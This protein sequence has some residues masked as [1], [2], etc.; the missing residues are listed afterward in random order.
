MCVC[1]GMLPAQ[2]RNAVGVAILYDE[3]TQ[4]IFTNI[5]PILGTKTTSF[6]YM[7]TN[8]TVVVVWHNLHKL[9]KCHSQSK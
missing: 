7:K 5:F 4:L 6:S 8:G 2:R 1:V 9:N 3:V